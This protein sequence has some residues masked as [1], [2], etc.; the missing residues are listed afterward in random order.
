MLLNIYLGTTA[1]SI[2]TVYLY[3]IAWQK[4][5]EKEGYVF[6]DKKESFIDKIVKNIS[7][8]LRLSIPVLNIIPVLTLIFSGDKL[9]EKMKQSFLYDGKIKYVYDKSYTSEQEKDIKMDMSP[10]ESN[11][12]KKSYSEM[13]VEEKLAYL[14]KEK[15]NLIN[16]QKDKSSKSHTR[17]R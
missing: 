3:S 1:I 11:E 15:Q 12:S 4:R 6:V 5:I 16:Q 13:T 9:Y 10:I 14:E 2:A 17:K 7:T 8:I